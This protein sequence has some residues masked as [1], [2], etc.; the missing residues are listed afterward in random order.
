MRNGVNA[1]TGLDRDMN[2]FERS[3]RSKNR[4][5]DLCLLRISGMCPEMFLGQL[6]SAYRYVEKRVVLPS[7]LKLTPCELVNVAFN[8]AFYSSVIPSC[9]SRNH[10]YYYYYYCCRKDP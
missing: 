8:Y 3:E 6:T 5:S 7:W 2:L 9:G 10:H 4:K 1:E